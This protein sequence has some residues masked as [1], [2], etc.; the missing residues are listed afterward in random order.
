MN[1][2]SSQHLVY[3]ELQFFASVSSDSMGTSADVMVFSWKIK[4]YK[5][6]KTMKVIIYDSNIIYTRYITK[7][8]T[9][10][11]D[12]QIICRLAVIQTPFKIDKMINTTLFS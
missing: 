12:L 8:T 1:S 10:I 3:S 11:Q 4:T 5:Y 7:H 6:S 2:C 9:V